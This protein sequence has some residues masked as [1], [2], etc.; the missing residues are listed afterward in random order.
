MYDNWST[1]MFVLPT[2]YMIIEVLIIEIPIIK[3]FVQSSKWGI[4]K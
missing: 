4:I 2:V 1:K 3:C